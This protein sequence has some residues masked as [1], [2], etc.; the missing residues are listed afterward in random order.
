MGLGRARR[1]LIL[2]DVHTMVVL[3]L[4]LLLVLVL[5]GNA[6]VSGEAMVANLLLQRV[7]PIYRKCQVL[8]HRRG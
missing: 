7:A 6:A 5:L 3:L 4:I 8:R 1:R 2:L